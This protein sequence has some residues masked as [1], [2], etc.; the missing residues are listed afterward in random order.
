LVGRVT[1]IQSDWFAAVPAGPFALIVSNPPYLSAE[2]TARAPLEVRGFEPVQA[3][4]AADDGLADLRRI[5]EGAPRFLAPGG[6]LALETGMAQHAPLLEIAA[7]AGLAQAESRRDLAGRD[8][9]ILA[10]A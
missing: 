9:F 3:L 2:E 7:A 5:I 10:R 8:R 1:F 6:L 4:A